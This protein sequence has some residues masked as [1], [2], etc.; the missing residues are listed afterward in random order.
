MPMSA[1]LATGKIW[2]AFLGQY[3]ESKS[4]FHGHSYGGNPLAAAVALATLEV[5]VEEQTLAAIQPK[6]A[7]LQKHLQRIAAHPHVGDVRQR[8]LVAG[9]ELVADRETKQPFDWSER[10]GQLVCDHALTEGV[11]LRPLGNVIVIMPPL[12]IAMDE[13]DRICTAVER[14]IEIAVG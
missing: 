5:F 7:C 6:I 2:Q 8:G 13:L 3:S 1:T 10:R 9:I 11:W 4:F 14:G 12:A